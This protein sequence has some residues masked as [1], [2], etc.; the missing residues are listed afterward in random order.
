MRA[1]HLD[2][3]RLE[4]RTKARGELPRE[5]DQVRRPRR[6]QV[7]R[8][9]RPADRLR[10]GA[11]ARPAERRRGPGRP[12]RAAALRRG[13]DVRP[14]RPTRCSTSRATRACTSWCASARRTARR[15]GCPDR[16]VE[17][18]VRSILQHAWASLQ[19]DLMYKG[20]R[21]PTDS[22]RRRLIALAGLLELADHEF[23]AVRL[24][25]RRRGRDA[26]RCARRRLRRG[27]G[28]GVGRAAGRRRGRRRAARVG[29]GP[30]RRADRARRDDGRRGDRAAGR[31]GRARARAG[32]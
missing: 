7:R 26:R 14:T 12:A 18:Q 10:R 22:V 9:G 19:H 29:G 32:S 11:R 30:A 16:P 4:T 23:M 28:A 27:R 25:P 31:V 21:A 3:A 13:G 8:P 5:G 6:V 15:W 20:E 2:D 17:L 1:A 24:G